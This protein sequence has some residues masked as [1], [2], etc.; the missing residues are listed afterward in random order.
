MKSSDAERAYQKA[1]REKPENKERAIE[2]RK[3]WSKEN[4]KHKN[5]IGRLYYATNEKFR[6]HKQEY[7]KEYRKRRKESNA[8]KQDSSQYIAVDTG[9]LPIM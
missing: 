5:E 6:A 7:M 1:Y 3:Q 4:Q 2:Y 8:Q 9:G